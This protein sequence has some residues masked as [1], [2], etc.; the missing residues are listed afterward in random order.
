ML[1]IYKRYQNL[2]LISM[3]V[4]GLLLTFFLQ[5]LVDFRIPGTILAH[6]PE[7]SIGIFLAKQKKFTVNNFA[8][9]G[10][11][12]IFVLSNI[13]ISLWL[14]SYSS[15]LL[16]MLIVFQNI[17]HRLNKNLKKYV[18]FIGSISMYMFYINGFMRKPWL[19]FARKIDIWYMS[20]LI[21]LIFVAIVILFSFFMQLFEEIAKRKIDIY[22]I[23][24]IDQQ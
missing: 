11:V 13:Y 18:V 2:G 10:I 4:V 19:S 1:L 7:L 14:L 8:I 21:C 15:A 22:R 9:F 24:K 6:I 3:S 23:K 20:F 5:P 12:V 16:L 17:L